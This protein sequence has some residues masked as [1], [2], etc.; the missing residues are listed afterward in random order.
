MR[1]DL[2]KT[3]VPVLILAMAAALFMGCKKP[4]SAVDTIEKDQTLEGEM[5][6]PTMP[7]TLTVP[8]EVK[9]RY[10]AVVFE[11]TNKETSEKKDYT[12]GIGQTA[13]L[14]DTG[15][16]IT[17]EAFLPSFTMAGNVFTSAGIDPNNPAAKVNIVDAAGNPPY[18]RFLFSLYP[19]THPYEHPK[20]T[21]FLKDFVVAK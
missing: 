16:T 12:V 3:A 19:L 1:I 6:T 10:K 17:V 9:A 13:P 21:V 18:T 7:T 8:D 4:V 2:R 20:Y 14:G 11:V 5:Q 15:L